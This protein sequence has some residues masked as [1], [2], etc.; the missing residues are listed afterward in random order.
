MTKLG[1]A[2][3]LDRWVERTRRLLELERQEEVQAVQ[4]ELA[5]RPD[6]ENPGVLSQLRV[7]QLSTGLFGRTLVRLELP[8]PHV[9]RPKPHQFSVGDLVQLRVEAPDGSLPTGIV[10]RV[11]DTAVSVALSEGQDVDEAALWSAGRVT[12]DRLVN[13]AT[14]AKLSETLDRLARHDGGAGQRLVDVVFSGVAPSWQT[15]LPTLTPFSDGLNASQLEAIRF[16]LASKDVA[17]IH[18]PPGTGKTTTVVELILQAVRT[19]GMKVLVCAPSNIAVDNVLEK[20][21][22][23]SASESARGQ[24]LQM[25]RVGHPARLLPQI[26]PFCLDARIERADGTEIVRDIRREMQQMETALQKKGKSMDRTARAEMRRE[27]KSNRKELRQREQRVVRELLAHSDVVFATNVGAAS[28]LLRDLT[29]D[30]VVIDEAAQ[31]LELSCWIPMRKAPRC[32]LAGDHHQLPPTIKSKAAAAQGLEITLFDRLSRREETKCVVRMLDTQYRMHEHISDWSSRAMYGGALQSAASVARRKLSDLPHVSL[33]LVEDPDRVNATLLLLDTAGCELEEDATDDDGADSLLAMS[34]SNRGEAEV[35]ARHV[36][37]L[38][39]AGL[40]THEIAVITPYN[41]QVQLLKALLLTEHPTLEIRSVDGFQGC[42]KEAVVM[43]LVRSNAAHEV[44]FLADDRRMN[45]AVTRA[46]RHV[47]IVCDTDTIRAHPFLKA[48]VEHFEQ[49]GEYRSAHEYLDE[50]VVQG[51]PSV[52]A[53]LDAAAA[54]SDGAGKKRA[55]VAAKQVTQQT[56]SQRTKA[57]ASATSKAEKQRVEKEST[58]DTRKEVVPPEEKAEDE[59]TKR[60]DPDD[61]ESSDDDDKDDDDGEPAERQPKSAFAHLLHDDS[62]DDSASSSEDEAQTEDARAE[63]LASA[64]TL[65]KE[66]HLS[67][68]ARQ[69][70][71]PAAPANAA[72]AATSTSKAKKKNKKKKTTTSNKQATTPAAVAAVDERADGEDDLAFLTR[73]VEQGTR[74]CFQRPAAASA[75]TVRC[76]K[77]T[78]TL[79]AVCRFCKLKYCYDHAQPEV[80]G[81]GDAVRAH[82]RQQFHASAAKA[83]GD[84][85]K[86]TIEKRRLLEKKLDASVSEKSAARQQKPSQKKKKGKK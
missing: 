31:A 36:G 13:N 62:S 85:K 76:K 3:P 52:V 7:A 19:F 43:S 69:S 56:P 2:M 8:S 86:L 44:G 65:L 12:L 25:T 4:Q 18:G 57:V 14:F 28:K 66:L 48:M 51:S 63:Q 17:L 72:A 22:D 49:V 78:L 46:K 15:P 61:G 47:A 11:D 16:A 38:L 53:S 20:M 55:T 39:R 81:C 50:G 23:A 10:A 68:L 33:G 80:H 29:F 1:P 21:A 34:K 67:R 60:V 6:A 54:A 40:K 77:S 58:T 42:E 30:L 59:E 26:L 79:G 64:N 83:S 75:A 41:K 82:E 27:L 32:V 24:R 84:V 71:A 35:V 45:V 5:T 74:C 73:Q 9:Q 37:E 70:A